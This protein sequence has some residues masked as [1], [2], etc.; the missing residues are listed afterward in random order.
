MVFLH[1]IYKLVVFKQNM[2]YDKFGILITILIVGA[3]FGYVAITDN[4]VPGIPSP[5]PEQVIPEVV[6]S[7][8]RL[9]DAYSNWCDAMNIECS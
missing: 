8:E 1:N 2:D 5:I 9:D 6:E 3:M 7:E 4:W